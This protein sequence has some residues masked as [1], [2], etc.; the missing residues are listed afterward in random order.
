[1]LGVVV[2]TGIAIVVKN[3]VVVVLV[4][5]FGVGLAVGVVLIVDVVN[6][7]DGTNIVLLVEWEIFVDANVVRLVLDDF[8]VDFVVFDV[9]FVVVD[10]VDVIVVFCLADVVVVVVK[11]VVVAIIKYKGVVSVDVD[12]CVVVVVEIDD[13]E[14]VVVAV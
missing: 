12:F 13:V 10:L 1:M 6:D 14:D 9:G 3:K 11:G 8:I 5:D 4:S 7:V 2:N